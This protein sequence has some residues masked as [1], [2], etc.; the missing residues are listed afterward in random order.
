MDPVVE[1][2]GE[3][4]RALLEDLLVTSVRVREGKLREL[5]G[6]REHIRSAVADVLVDVAEDILREYPD[7]GL[8]LE[9]RI[10]MMAANLE[11]NLQRIFQKKERETARVQE[12]RDA[13]IRKFCD[14]KGSPSPLPHPSG[15]GE[16][17]RPP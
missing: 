17:E 13:A 3:Q 4:R 7:A 12:E 1:G 15:E 16:L 8:W 9:H 6:D 10:A 14:G 11:Y 5:R 2:D